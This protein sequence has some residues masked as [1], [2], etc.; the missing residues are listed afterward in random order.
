MWR[1]KF[2]LQIIVF[3]LSAILIDPTRSDGKETS[4]NKLPARRVVL[5]SVDG[6]RAELAPQM[7]VFNT[8]NKLG[9]WTLEAEAPLPTITTVSHAVMF[10][11]A[12]PSKN[13]VT[14][15]EPKVLGELIG[16]KAALA[17]RPLQIKTIFMAVKEAGW[18][19][20]AFA[21][22]SKMAGL[23]PPEALTAF[24][25]FSESRPLV[26]RAC[27]RIVK[28]PRDALI[29]IHLKDLDKTGHVYGW[30]SKEQLA[31][32]KTIDQRLARLT[33]CLKESE[34]RNGVPIVLILTT[35]HGGHGK[36]HGTDLPADRLVPLLVV[37]PGIKRGHKIE[38]PVALLNIAPTILKILQLKPNSLPDAEGK[39]I[40][41]IFKP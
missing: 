29:F 34:R 1:S 26:E 40:D 32:A 8:L 25:L 41:E 5:I 22:A 30:L 28:E 3:L 12:P 24:K 18:Q 38:S 27:S 16:L 4:K 13:G 37:G 20:A 21:H 19:T 10:T 35:D 15:S 9:A 6:W 11:G 23:F 2:I 31:V 17:W 7:R 14:T 36:I 33:K 39:V